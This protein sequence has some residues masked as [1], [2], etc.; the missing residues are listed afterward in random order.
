MLASCVSIKW[1]ERFKSLAS[2]KPMFEGFL[3]AA[4][5][6]QSLDRYMKLIPPFHIYFISSRLCDITGCD[7]F[8]TR[9][10]SSLLNNSPFLQKFL[11]EKEKMCMLC[12]FNDWQWVKLTKKMWQD[13][14]SHIMN[15]W[16]LH[17]LGLI[18]SGFTSL[19]VQQ[20]FY[21]MMKGLFHSRASN[22]RD[23]WQLRRDLLSQKPLSQR[24]WVIKRHFWDVTTGFK[25]K[26]LNL[27]HI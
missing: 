19:K 27:C 24:R 3:Y 26:Y 15:Q 22:M 6:Q 21:C 17:L 4:W 9:C 12:L 2:Q 13:L 10:S 11:S 7:N 5:L 18:P 25:V 1:S 14:S 8:L 23:V 20:L 16:T